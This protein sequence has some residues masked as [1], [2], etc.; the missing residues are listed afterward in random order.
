MPIQPQR[1]ALNNVIPY[2]EE[3]IE[4]DDVIVR[5][6]DSVNHII[7]DGNRNIRRISTKAFRPSTDQKYPGMSIDVPKLIEAENIDPKK[8]ITNPKYI[9]S[10]S[11]KAEA[12]RR[13]ALMIGFDPVQSVPS[14]EDNPYHGQIWKLDTVNPK[15]SR[16]LQKWFLKNA[17]WYV[18]IPDVELC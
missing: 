14:L 16:E 1:D 6:I 4:N 9:G 2:D 8:F 10:V 7:P 13:Q 17:D 12:V 5:R 15:F 18:E 11:F 3:Q